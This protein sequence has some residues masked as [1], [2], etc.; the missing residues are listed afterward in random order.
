MRVMAKPKK[1]LSRTVRIDL[2]PQGQPPPAPIHEAAA[3]PTEPPSGAFIAPTTPVQELLQHLYDAALITNLR[4]RI[5][6]ANPRAVEFLRYTPDEICGLHTSDILHGADQALI[7]SFV[8]RLEQGDFALIQGYCLRKDGTTFPAEVAVNMLRIGEK[9]LC[10]FL[11]DITV[12]K[13]AEDLMRT[14]F[15][16]IKN[17]A[18][19]IAMLDLEGVLTYAN[20]A[21]H[22]LWGAHEKDALVGQHA[23][24][25]FSDEGAARSMLRRVLDLEQEWTGLLGAR[26]ANGD[27]FQVQVTAAMNRDSEGDP[28]GAVLSVLDMT[29][30]HR[31]EEALRET[32]RQNAMLASLNAASHHLAQPA[33]VLVGN[34]SLLQSV[35][36]ELPA[37]VRD[38]VRASSEAAQE[39]ARILQRLL[40][41][42][43]YRTQPYL[44]TL[45][46]A[47]DNRML[48]IDPLTSGGRGEDAKSKK[49]RGT[50]AP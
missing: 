17:A 48:R 16:A 6:E 35:A 1:N 49:P 39:L 23:L 25:L 5:R 44:A 3:R 26:R 45:P 11:R 32:E 21:L 50:P 42:T 37:N 10:F 12:R 7:E 31:A 24:K 14:A 29:D 28:A 47:P 13:R 22:R 30:A 4:G 19:G 8:E 33:T 43:K 18:V 36:G 9:R 40:L 46:E 41:V 38:I 15:D 2:I 20:P 34:L 27:E